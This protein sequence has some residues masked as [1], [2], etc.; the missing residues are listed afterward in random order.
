MQRF[1]HADACRLSPLPE[2]PIRE[3][4][5]YERPAVRQVAMIDAGHFREDGMIPQAARANDTVDRAIDRLRAEEILTRPER[6]MRFI[7]QNTRA[8]RWEYLGRLHGD[9]A[10]LERAWGD[11]TAEH[12]RWED[13]VEIART[14]LGR[15]DTSVE[16]TEN[17]CIDLLQSCIELAAADASQGSVPGVWL[18]VARGFAR[19]RS[20]LAGLRSYD[21]LG[22]LKLRAAIDG[23]VDAADLRKA[24]ETLGVHGGGGGGDGAV[25]LGYPDFISLEWLLR[26]DRTHSLPTEQLAD[27]L[28]RAVDARTESDGIFRIL[29]LRSAA[30]LQ[31]HAGRTDALSLVPESGI[32]SLRSLRT[33]ILGD[34]KPEGI[35]RRCP[36]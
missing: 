7:L 15:S 29:A 27:A 6:F 17:Q 4:W 8:R 19:S 3:Q 33:A 14:D 16:R 32:A 12:G 9:A 30:V 24:A 5:R 34:G 23:G 1:G 10:H 35:M 31:A 2:S 26:L 13:L 28:Q 18:E 25:A 20:P 36:Y 22:W 21:L 11:L